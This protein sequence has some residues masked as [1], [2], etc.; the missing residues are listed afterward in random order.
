MSDQNLKQL[1]ALD[2]APAHDP[3]FELRVL[4]GIERRRF[5]RNVAGLVPVGAA[6]GVVAWSLAPLLDAGTI[7]NPTLLSGIIVG[8]TLFVVETWQ[9]QR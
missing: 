7:N 6:I 9:T 3:V 2:E 5:W 1:L 8:T 4:A